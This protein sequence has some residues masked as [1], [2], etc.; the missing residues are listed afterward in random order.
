MDEISI[1][2]ATSLADVLARNTY[3]NIS[4]RISMIKEKKKEEEKQAAYEEIIN[5]LLEDKMD[6]QR[7]AGEY[8]ELY[9]KVTISDEDIEHLQKTA[10]YVVKQFNFFSPI[11]ENQQNIELL[12]Q[13]INKDTLKTM[14]LLGFNYR[15]A[16]GQPLTEVCASSIKKSLGGSPKTRQKK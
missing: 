13:L 3:N 12:L 2:L 4:T 10:K 14:Q 15:E 11:G 8:K 9:E 7:I 1:R 16:I 5:E 6:L